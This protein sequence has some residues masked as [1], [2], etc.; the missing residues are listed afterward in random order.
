VQNNG[1]EGGILLLIRLQCRRQGILWGGCLLIEVSVAIRL[2]QEVLN[3][4]SIV[5]VP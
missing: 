5:G 1:I 4:D 2:L 3:H